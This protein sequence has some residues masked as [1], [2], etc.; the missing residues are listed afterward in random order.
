MPPLNTGVGTLRHADRRPGPTGVLPNFDL[1]PDGERILALMPG[2]K[3]QEQQ[4][5]IHVTFILN[6]SDE[7]R[8]R[9]HPD[10]K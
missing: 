10:T 2:A 9:M 6:F 1:S 4:T 3:P 8:R 5:Q 7:V